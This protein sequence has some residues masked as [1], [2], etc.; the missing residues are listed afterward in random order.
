MV[1]LKEEMRGNSWD[2]FITLKAGDHY[3]ER[4]VIII[5]FSLFLD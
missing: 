3:E 5:N 1:S 2:L 4:E